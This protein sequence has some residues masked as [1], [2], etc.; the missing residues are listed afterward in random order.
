M[1]NPLSSDWLDTVTDRVPDEGDQILIRE[2]VASARTGA[3]RLAVIGAWLAAAESLKRRFQELAQSD[4]EAGRVMAEVDQREN[5]QRSVD[6]FLV[7]KAHDYGLTSV[8]EDHALRALYEARNVFGHPYTEQPTEDDVR[9]AIASA[10]D[11]LLSKPLL[12]RHRFVREEIARITQRRGWLSDS[13]ITVRTRVNFALGRVDPS[14][15]AY[16]FTSLIR[17]AD[18]QFEDIEFLEVCSPAVSSGF[19]KA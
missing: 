8:V 15:H 19:S 3:F 13:P 16:F 4:A 17:A 1:S 5:S 12:M 10:V 6:R 18:S 9:G 7:G 11:H 2:A 14:I